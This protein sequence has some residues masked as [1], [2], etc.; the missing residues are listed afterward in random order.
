MAA[1]VFIGVFLLFSRPFRTFTCVTVLITI[2]LLKSHFPF[3]ALS[4]LR[5]WLFTRCPEYRTRPCP[6][7][8]S[9]QNKA[10][11]I[12]SHQDKIKL[13]LILFEES[14]IRYYILKIFSSLIMKVK[15]FSSKRGEYKVDI[16]SPLFRAIYKPE[17]V[18]ELKFYYLLVVILL[19]C[20]LQVI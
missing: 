15:S 8:Y 10:K 12:L 19:M 17:S 2:M 13:C 7:W 1:S 20:S 18:P 3:L 9:N 14:A 4:F 5:A 11:P 6:S 16:T